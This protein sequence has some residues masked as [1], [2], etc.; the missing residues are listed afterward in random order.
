MVFLFNVSVS[1][2]TH[3][4]YPIPSSNILVE[5]SAVFQESTPSN[6][7]GKRIIHVHINAQPKNDSFI[8]SA[9]VT[10]YSLDHQSILGPYIVDCGETLSVDIDDR[11]WG[12][13]V[14]T[15]TP[16]EVSVCIDGLNF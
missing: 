13:L 16:V 1:G 2:Q 9:N 10:I 15:T 4:P 3:I 12:V 8:C 6:C 14:K 5:T 7:D 11:E